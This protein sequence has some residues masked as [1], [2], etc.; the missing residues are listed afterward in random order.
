V[1]QAKQK[2]AAKAGAILGAMRNGRAKPERGE[3]GAGWAEGSL[4]DAA[5]SRRLRQVTLSKSGMNGAWSPSRLLLHG[6]KL[7]IQRGFTL[8]I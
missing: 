6:I 5:A 4:R 3:Q 2:T 8:E 1:L 7:E